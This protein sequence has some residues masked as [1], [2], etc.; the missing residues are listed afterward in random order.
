MIRGKVRSCAGNL[1]DL[2]HRFPRSFI[3]RRCSR[4][5][6]SSERASR[7]ER[8]FAANEEATRAHCLVAVLD[9]PEDSLCLGMRE[10]DAMDV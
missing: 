4:R 1:S 7:F 8:P 3:F 9:V 2:N 6:D 5:D 10:K